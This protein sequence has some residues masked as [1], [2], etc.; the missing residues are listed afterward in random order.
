MANRKLRDVQKSINEQ[1]PQYGPAQP[2]NVGETSIPNCPY[3]GVAT[4]TRSAGPR[5]LPNSSLG[6]RQHPAPIHG[7]KA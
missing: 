1:G 4:P 5:T 3:D 6:A 7:K 2:I